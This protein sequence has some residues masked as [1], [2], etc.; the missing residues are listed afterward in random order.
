M[1]KYRGCLSHLRRSLNCNAQAVNRAVAENFKA[2]CLE[3]VSSPTA[4]AMPQV[5]PGERVAIASALFAATVAAA[6]LPFEV[7]PDVFN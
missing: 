7:K 4:R 6:G 3:R 2:A 5:E 1:V